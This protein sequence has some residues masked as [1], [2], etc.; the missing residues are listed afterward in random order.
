MNL[1]SF[2]NFRKKIQNFEITSYGFKGLFIVSDKED[3]LLISQFEDSQIREIYY[4]K[5]NNTA[6]QKDLEIGDEIVI[7]IDLS[8]FPSYYEKFEDF[9]FSNRYKLNLKEYY[10]QEL[11]FYYHYQ[12]N[13]Q[14]KTVNNYINLLELITFLKELS[15]YEKTTK[16]V[17]ELY[18]QK[19]D[20]ICSIVL[21][22][23]REIIENLKINTSIKELSQHVFEKSDQETRKKLFANEMINF[24]SGGG[25]TFS[26]VVNSWDSICNSYMNSFQIYLS[27][28]SFEKIKT[29]SQEYFHELTDRIYS[30]IHKFSA[31]ILAIPVAYI[32]ILRFFDFEGRS[33]VKDS[34]LLILGLLYFIIIW[35]VFLNNLT[36]AFETIEQDIDKFLKRIKGAENLA[37]IM[38]SLSNQK[39]KLIPSQR[40]KIIIVRVISVLILFMIFG[41]FVYIYYDFLKKFVCN[42]N[43]FAYSNAY[44]YGKLLV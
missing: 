20:R 5:N 37:E 29:S 6:N 30:T 25:F 14:N 4:K 3:L 1:V 32:L 38:E 26:N 36:Q 13:E 10:I 35:F 22:Y 12:K 28:F 16:G 42:L 43:L 19:P 33:F 21:D 31:F 39:K 27:E 9:T 2:V 44:K 17:L 41:A 15:T 24:L 11:N 34:F 8:K 7:L 40:R 18:F 23:N